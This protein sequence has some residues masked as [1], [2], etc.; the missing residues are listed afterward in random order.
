MNRNRVKLGLAL[1][2]VGLLGAGEALAQDRY[3]VGDIVE[4]F[5][6]IDRATGE[7]VKLSD[8]AGHVIFLEWF[9]YW[10]PFRQS[11]AAEVAPGIVDYYAE[12]NGNLNGVPVKHVA[13]NLEGG[14]ET[15]T[16]NFV[17]FY[18][19]GLVLNDFDRGL[20][21]RFQS[22]G[23]PIFAI[24]NGVAN[25]PSH[26]QWELLYSHL[27]YGELMSPIETFR[28]E[29]D[30][31]MAA[32]EPD[33]DPDPD[34]EP[35]PNAAPVVIFDPTN[36]TVRT[37]DRVEF[38]AAASGEGLSYQW[39]KDGQV[40]AGQTSGRLVLASA[41]AADA[42]AY[43]VEISNAVGSVVSAAGQLALS[44]QADGRLINLSS[45]SFSGAGIE[46][47]VPSFV[48]NGPMT[49]LVRA[50]GPTLEDFGVAG[51]L[52]DPQFTLTAE[53]E[54]VASNDNWGAG[55]S[56]SGAEIREIAATV[57]GFALREG[58]ADA[59]LVYRY[60]GGPRTA[61]VTDGSGE[62]G[63]TL[64][65][66]YAVPD[67]TLTGRLA[68]LA[69]RG[70][71]RSGE[72]LVAGFVLGGDR[73]RTLLIRGAGPELA[74]FGVPGALVDPVIA[75]AQDGVEFVSNDDWSSDSS[76]S[77]QIATVAGTA[78]AF[79]LGQ[80]SADAALLITL[81][82]GAYTV[83]V[84]GKDGASGIVLAEIYDVTGL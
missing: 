9:A 65:E 31:V 12:Q 81:S 73:A 24:I 82:P 66:V 10:C 76:T 33:P 27:G 15:A 18:K 2:M 11:A 74:N 72:P 38:V 37:G 46:Q 19:L 59:A 29:I 53:G 68:N 1:A 23:Q 70:L 6:L 3:Q 36:Q 8:L 26:Q 61:P 62:T 71:V 28:A 34:P 63:G 14:D 30:A 69:A 4:D 79:P 77:A 5:E 78:G 22:G 55:S 13:I 60:D 58:G 49:L 44:E 41:D 64:V 84:T 42:G 54:V 16:Q 25:S 21:N 17:D 40:I 67:Q 43:S 45:R 48:A 51:V 75:I 39:R 83:Q 57:G 50:V 7:P 80:G 35:E 52:P 20:A 56:A 32:T 47:L